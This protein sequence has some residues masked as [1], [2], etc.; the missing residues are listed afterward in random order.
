MAIRNIVVFHPS[1]GIS[2]PWCCAGGLPHTLK[3]LGYAV[4]SFTTTS[5]PLE[6]LEMA[7]LIILS[8]PEW[9]AAKI[10]ELFGERWNTLK[11][12]KVAWYAESFKRDDRDFDFQETAWI[13]DK[14]YFP[15]HQDAEEHGGEWLP[16]GVD[17]TLFR[18]NGGAKQFN[19][20][21]IGSLY[22]KR[23][24]YIK[25]IECEI[26]HI[27]SVYD[28]DEV[29]STQML[30]EAYAASRIFVNLPSYSRLLVTKITEVLACGTM[31]L[32]P[33]MDHPSAL[34][35][36][37][38]FEHGR[39]LIYYSPEKPAEI[40]EY[41]NHFMNDVAGREAIARAGM[42]EVIEKHSLESRLRKIVADAISA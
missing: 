12:I 31:L 37:S 22:Q 29:R 27:N 7:D 34:T 24:D 4:T 40:G 9:Y 41:I 16:F 25:G 8:A 11:A 33:M 32:T 20:A 5:A 2:T 42:Q 19:A 36:M 30:A 13:A 15:A 35:N 10:R 26:S 14:H 6:V 28:A 18:P 1:T 39:H 23:M 21:F 3:R 17:T 38:Q